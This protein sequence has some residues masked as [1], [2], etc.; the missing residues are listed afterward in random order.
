M[1]D[2]A[3][4][5]KRQRKACSHYTDDGS[6]TQ[7]ARTPKTTPATQGTKRRKSP[8]VKKG[9]A[10][11]CVKEGTVLASSIQIAK[12]LEGSACLAGSRP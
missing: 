4:P 12:I 11:S 3:T 2:S 9:V 1:Q 7:L 5:A 6:P 8:N 10:A